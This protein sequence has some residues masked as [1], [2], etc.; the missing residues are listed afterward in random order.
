MFAVGS[1]V[2]ITS[3]ACALPQGFI[4]VVLK[5]EGDNITLISRGSGYKKTETEYD[6]N[7]QETAIVS[8][9]DIEL[10]DPT[11]YTRIE[12]LLK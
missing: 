5:V 2:R 9:A 11:P 1:F 3:P 4:S 10:L 12:R 7:I 8:A 6:L